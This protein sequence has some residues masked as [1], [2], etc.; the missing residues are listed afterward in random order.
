M[1][2]DKTNVN[3]L[4]ALMLAHGIKDVVVCPGSRNGV[5]VHNFVVAGSGRLP[6]GT[7]EEHI[8]GNLFTT[9]P[10][11]D[12]RSAAF[13][14]LGIC[15]AVR[16]PVAICVT[17]GSALL[18]MLPAVAEAYYRHMPLL[19]ISA[20]RPARWIGQLDGQTI[21][22]VGAL[23]PYARTFNLEEP[24]DDEEHWC[25]NRKINEAL[26]SL[27]HEGGKPVHVNVPVSEPLFSFSTPNLPEERVVKE[28]SS[29]GNV[30]LPKEVLDI[31]RQARL[32]VLL[33]GQCDF[34]CPAV[35]S[36][37]EEK[38]SLLVLPE[39]VGNCP[40]SWRTC[41]LENGTVGI[42]PDVV[43]HIGGHLVNK[44]LKLLL[45][46]SK[47][48]RVIRIASDNGFPDTFGHLH[49]VVR[50][51][52]ESA[53]RQ[54]AERLPAHAGV[55][56]KR[57]EMERKRGCAAKFVPQ[58]F[59]DIGVMYRLSCCLRL[60]DLGAFHLGN[61]S[62]VRNATY[63]FDGGVCPVFCNRGVN[64]IEGT[65][66]AAVGYSLA[67]KG[68]SLVMVGDL[69]FFYDQNALW[70]RNVGSNLRILLFNNGGGQIFRRLPGLSD[71][72]ARDTYIAAGHS[73]SAEGIAAA[74]G[75]RYMAVRDYHDW[76]LSVGTLL[77]ARQQQPVLLEVFTNPEDNEADRILLNTF[78]QKS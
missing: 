50:T 45:R 36:R 72:A 68:V 52:P 71:T 49:M 74:F 60:Q 77:D 33:V 4:T 29:S 58:H 14:A 10:V 48:C 39:I 35:W 59:S 47:D 78:Y 55:V 56:A 31:V 34:L 22:Q 15:L 66:S 18:N 6:V 65:L 43:V 9:Y 75:L 57:K 17:S 67:D 13:V 16:R 2:C 3:Q 37:I 69:S 61:S 26:L 46:S 73:D 7:P 21:P 32:P 51:A 54:M 38:G 76:D 44:R 30:P 1:Y 28:F 70:N 27:S 5:L 11:T 23:E 25:C 19:L 62:V 64:G 40:G 24:K 8:G 53:L 20:D 42:E 12:E 41:L 63:F